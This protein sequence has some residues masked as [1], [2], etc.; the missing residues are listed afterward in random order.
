MASAEAFILD[1]L[2]GFPQTAIWERGTA[3]A[4]SD[5][6]E[7]LVVAYTVTGTAAYLDGV[8]VSGYPAEFGVYINTVRK[9]T[10]YTEAGNL[11]PSLPFNNLPLPIGTVLEVRVTHYDASPHDFEATIR[12]HR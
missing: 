12:G 2:K 7:T 6:D 8:S 9:E 10:I 11:S 5:N 1:S 4:V 3:E